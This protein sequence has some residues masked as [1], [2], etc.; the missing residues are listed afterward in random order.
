MKIVLAPDSFK[1]SLT[2]E[3]AVA[4]MTDGI[5]EVSEDIIIDSIPVADGGEGT[6]YSV[7]RLFGGQTVTEKV[8]GPYGD[9]VEAS[10]LLKAGTA[11]I[12]MAESSG[13]NLTDKRDVIHSSTYG[14]GEL[15]MDAVRRGAKRIYVTFGGS[16]TNDGGVGILCALG[17]RITDDEG[18]DIEP[19]NFGLQRLYRIDDSGVDRS[20]YDTEFILACDVRN[21]LCGKNGATYV[22][23]PQKGGRGEELEIMDFN[24]FR[25]AGLL[26]KQTGRK[27]LSVEGSGAAGGATVPFL[28]FFD[29]RVERGI[30]FVLSLSG[31]EDRIGDADLIFTGEGRYDS[32]TGYGKVISGIRQAADRKGVRLIVFAGSTE[33]DEKDVFEISDRTRSLE[34]NMVNAY[35]NLRHCT[36][37]FLRREISK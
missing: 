16:A 1:G 23:G 12:E 32:Q 22:F 30:D 7:K 5:R 35:E 20:L 8:R 31:F 24:L 27:I 3:E 14:T 36:A 15:I 21:T 37:G 26:E 34:Y 28:A 18:N 19:S 17:F 6:L 29:S 10:Y 9:P 13:L 11:L 2:Q 25:Y 33:M 4:A